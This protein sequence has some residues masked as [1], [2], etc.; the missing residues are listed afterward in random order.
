MPVRLTD[1]VDSDPMCKSYRGGVGKIYGWTDALDTHDWK[2]DGERVI[3][4]MP[5]VIYVEFPDGTWQRHG[6]PP[7]VY[8]I[9]SRNRIWL[10]NR[11]TGHRV[12]S[13]EVTIIPKKLRQHHSYDTGLLTAEGFR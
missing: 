8:P 11:K 7:N 10:L 4:T 2:N 9:R 13:K 3:D 5:M 1:T 6:R 12:R